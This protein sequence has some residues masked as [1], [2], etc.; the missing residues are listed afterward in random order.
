MATSRDFFSRASSTNPLPVESTAESLASSLGVTAR[1]EE[2]E[3]DEG[4]VSMAS[5]GNRL[6]LSY[7]EVWERRVGGGGGGDNLKIKAKH[8]VRKDLNVH[9]LSSWLAIFK[10]AGT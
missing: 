6:L 5:D 10:K 9:V 1:E 7:A 2:E 3:E 8:S 4:G